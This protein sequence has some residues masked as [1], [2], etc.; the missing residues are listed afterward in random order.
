M[1]KNRKEAGERLAGELERFR[2]S[3]PL[4]LAIPKG[5]VEVGYYAASGINAEF[6]IIIVRKL[7]FPDNPE[8]GFGAVAEDGS[9]YMSPMAA[10]FL[11]ES[12]I[13]L[14]IEEQREEDAWQRYPLQKSLPG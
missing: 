11:P 14:I 8:S 13:S 7:P 4:L 12:A 6:S 5:G 1:F 3:N 2:S 10:E 9:V